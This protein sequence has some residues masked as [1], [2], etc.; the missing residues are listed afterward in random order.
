MFLYF[1]LF[2]SAELLL[3]FPTS[4]SREHTALKIDA[5][6]TSLRVC[7][8]MEEKFPF[9]FSVF[10]RALLQK[11]S[12]KICSNSS[13]CRQLSVIQA[14]VSLSETLESQIRRLVMSIMTI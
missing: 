2:Y 1:Y 4:V 8:Q 5:R 12:A 10:L 14:L 9:H 11:D 6:L 3:K 7:S 13:N